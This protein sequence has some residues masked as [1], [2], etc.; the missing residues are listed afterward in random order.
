MGIEQDRAR[1]I[2]RRAGQVVR[3]PDAQRLE[4]RH[5]RILIDRGLLR[6][7]VAVELHHIEQPVADEAQRQGGGFIDKHA[8]AQDLSGEVGQPAGMSGREVALG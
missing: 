7:L 6:R 5:P 1:A 4:K 8:D 2:L 3:R